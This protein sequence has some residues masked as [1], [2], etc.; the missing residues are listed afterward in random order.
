M[1]VQNPSQK[2]LPC[3]Q[4]IQVLPEIVA[5]NFVVNDSQAVIKS[6]TQERFVPRVSDQ[7]LYLSSAICFELAKVTKQPPSILAEQFKSAI[8]EH[9]LGQYFKDRIKID[10]GG[11]LNIQLLTTDLVGYHWWEINLSPTTEISVLLPSRTNSISDFSYLRLVASL[12]LFVK[13]R[14]NRSL[15]T[16]ITIGSKKH[17][18]LLDY[19]QSQPWHSENTSKEGLQEIGSFISQSSLQQKSILLLCNRQFSKKILEQE[20]LP[21][22]KN[23]TLDI[24]EFVDRVVPPQSEHLKLRFELANQEFSKLL[25]YLVALRAVQDFDPDGWRLGDYSN[26]SNYLTKTA[27]RIAQVLGSLGQEFQSSS[28]IESQCLVDMIPA[29]LAERLLFVHISLSRAL[30][31]PSLVTCLVD[32]T[33]GLLDSFSQ[34]FNSPAIRQELGNTDLNSN[35]R[36]VALVKIL[37]GFR[38]L[39]L[40]ILNLLK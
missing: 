2:V 22:S 14:S 16:D 19:L 27:A 3:Y 37:T 9:Q 32:D 40:S 21:I 1:N 10:G 25:C 38:A 15:S 34:W 33:R 24:V 39:F 6:L 30:E 13:L 12:V 11:F 28:T 7:R 35:E 20:V 8:L 23:I 29:E 17:V 36:G 18:D 26:L 31:L 5:R 4:L